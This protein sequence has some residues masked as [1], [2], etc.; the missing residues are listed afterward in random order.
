MRM[1]GIVELFRDS[2]SK[3]RSVG[4]IG[5][6]R[7]PDPGGDRVGQAG[8]SRHLSRRG[9]GIEAGA[10][11]FFTGLALRQPADLRIIARLEAWV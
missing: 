10:A 6:A 5:I 4:D 3:Y 1:R 2:V 8:A 7:S 11:R 9:A